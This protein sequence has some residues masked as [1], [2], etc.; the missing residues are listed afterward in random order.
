MFTESVQLAR[1][2]LRLLPNTKNS[3]LIE[4]EDRTAAACIHAAAAPPADNLV[5][6]DHEVPFPIEWL[7]QR[8]IVRSNVKA[9]RR[10]H[11]QAG[12]HTCDTTHGAEIHEWQ[13]KMDA[14]H[15]GEIG[16]ASCRERVL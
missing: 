13:K 14:S 1:Y 11:K 4:Q 6:T 12:P 7:E 10:F 2:I 3:D 9:L 15:S 5:L 16:R 8:K